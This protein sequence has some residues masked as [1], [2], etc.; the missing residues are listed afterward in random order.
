[1]KRSIYALLFIHLVVFAISCDKSED[2]DMESSPLGSTVKTAET[3]VNDG[4]K[5]YYTRNSAEMVE[6]KTLL[7]FKLVIKH[8][9]SMLNCEAGKITLECQAGEGVISI[10][11]KEESTA[12]NCVCPYDLTYTI[13][14]PGYGKYKLIIND[15][16]F[17]EFEF[18]STTNT[19][20][21]KYL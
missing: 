5:K 18:T 13:N 1:M 14:M 12:A 9:D 11:E 16:E 2:S 17:G 19:T 4:C 10:K 7:G 15:Y 21:R 20:L 8:I 6:I 3:I